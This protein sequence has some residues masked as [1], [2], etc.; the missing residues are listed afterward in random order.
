MIY[1]TDGTSFR[2]KC[3]DSIMTP[4]VERTLTDAQTWLKENTKRYAFKKLEKE[5]IKPGI[6]IECGT[7]VSNCPVDAITSTRVEH[8]YVPELTGKCTA[9]GLCYAMC[10]RTR[11][12]PEDLIGEYKG[13]FKAQSRSDKGTRQDGGVATA[14]IAS[15]LRAKMSDAAVVA[16]QSDNKWLPEAT[17]A[18]TEEEVFSSGGT[19]YTHTPIVEGVMNAIKTGYS[20]IAVV[21]TACNIDALTRL[22][23]HPAGFLA[24]AKDTEILKV[25]LF[26]MESFDYEGLKSFL[27]ENSVDIDKIKRMAIAGGKFTIDIE[28]SDQL[29]WPIKEL[30]HI[31]ARSCSYCHDLTAKNSDITCGNIGS[32]DGWTTVIVRTEKGK[33]AFELAIEQGLIEAEEL[34]D[35]SIQI[36]MNVARSKATRYYN[37]EPSH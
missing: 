4:D 15:H 30:D 21:G 11:M 22:Q 8:K 31:A 19:I 26:C 14:V 33:K 36:I 9:C 2:T 20:K 24:L 25:G 27:K 17:I 16:H 29:E 37:M 7:C 3:G 18:L 35:N 23:T 10:P 13:V 28:G 1:G 32:D 34:D 6:C 12:L 5:I